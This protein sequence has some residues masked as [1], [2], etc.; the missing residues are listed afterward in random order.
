MPAE[1]TGRDAVAAA[2]GALRGRVGEELG[3]TAWES[4]DLAAIRAYGALT[5]EDL[6]IHTDAERAAASRFG[7]PLVQASL[8]M[9]RFGAWIRAVGAWLPEPAVP[10]NYGYDKVRILG[11]LK[12]GEP[13]RGRVVLQG[14]RDAPGP[15]VRLHLGVSAE[16]ES[17]GRPVI[18]AEWI[19]AFLLDAAE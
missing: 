16:R 3:T 7:A 15:M 6:W 5:G 8:L 2:L 12:A 17:G 13:V 19:V 10:L 9:A 4:H 11:A 18:A 1:A 14:L